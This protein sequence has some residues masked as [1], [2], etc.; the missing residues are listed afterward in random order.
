[1]E[2]GRFGN[3]RRVKRERKIA[4]KNN[5]LVRKLKRIFGAVSKT[6]FAVGNSM[7]E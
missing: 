2:I 3:P 7:D 4:K 5:N 1:L 6:P